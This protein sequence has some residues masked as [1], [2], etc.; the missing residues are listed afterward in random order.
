MGDTPHA[1]GRWTVEELLLA[2]LAPLPLLR[3]MLIHRTTTPSDGYYRVGLD[4]RQLGDPGVRERGDL[5][6][7]GE[8]AR[9]LI[10]RLERDPAI[11]ERFAALR[12]MG[13]SVHLGVYDEPWVS[14][15]MLFIALNQDAEA[16]LREEVKVAAGVRTRAES[17]EFDRRLTLY[18]N[19]RWAPDWQEWRERH[20]LIEWPEVSGL[21]PR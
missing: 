20:P 7:Y 14:T 10:D 3:N 2:M 5:L 13:F 12:A 15:L 19:Q 6:K 11:A 1:S 8:E 18:I 4:S 9:R 16:R 17:E 21:R